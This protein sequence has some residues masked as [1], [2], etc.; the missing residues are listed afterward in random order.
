MELQ[1]SVGEQIPNF[2][3]ILEECFFFENSLLV[4]LGFPGAQSKSFC[5]L[6]Y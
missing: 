1:T 3:E 2:E 4:A 5:M 6:S